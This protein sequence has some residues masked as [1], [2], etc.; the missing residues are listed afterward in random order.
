MAG[1]RAGCIGCLGLIGALVLVAIIGAA[2]SATH[3]GGGSISSSNG[4]HAGTRHVAAHDFCAEATADSNKSVAREKASDHRGAYNAAQ[5]GLKANESC[6]DG[7]N[8]L[9]NEAYL[10]SDRAFSEHYLAEG[11]WRTDFN[12]SN[13]L[14]VECQTRPGLYGTHTGASCET[15]E[16]YNIRQTTNWEMNE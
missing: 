1:F 15:Q 9:L 14:L 11:D 4:G 7:D 3:S 2:I 13:A 10:L 16:G 12:Q 6:E 5:A 8:H